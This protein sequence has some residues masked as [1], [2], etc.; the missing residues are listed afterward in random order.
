[1]RLLRLRVSV[2]VGSIGLRGY[3]EVVEGAVM[4]GKVMR[5]W[6]SRCGDGKDGYEG[7]VVATEVNLEGRR[8]T[9]RTHELWMME[10]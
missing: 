5:V 7:V 3:A 6:M 2:S 10:S 8:A 9:R 1:M 4:V